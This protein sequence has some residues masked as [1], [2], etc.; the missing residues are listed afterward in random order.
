MRPERRKGQRTRSKLFEVFAE[1]G[2]LLIVPRSPEEL[3]EPILDLVEA[4]IEP[5]RAI[6]LLTDC[7]GC[8]PQIKA[9]R[10]RDGSGRGDLTLSQS[11][12][13]R[14][15]TEKTSFCWKTAAETTA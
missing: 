9:S 14:V 8:E 5:E 13:K 10:L 1:A 12:V 3:F 11:M 15:L 6:L 4:A 2:D 7:E